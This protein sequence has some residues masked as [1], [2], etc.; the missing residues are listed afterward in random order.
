MKKL[1]V[2]MPPAEDL[3]YILDE[4]ARDDPKTQRILLQRVGAFWDVQWQVVLRWLK[5]YQMPTPF[6]QG[7]RGPYK[8]S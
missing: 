7:P 8:K 5:C 1:P 6:T 2:G 4:V 3:G